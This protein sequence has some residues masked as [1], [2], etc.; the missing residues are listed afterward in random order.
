MEASINFLSYSGSLLQVLLKLITGCCYPGI[1]QYP[2][3]L[4]PIVLKKT[5]VGFCMYLSGFLLS[6]FDSLTKVLKIVSRILFC[7]FRSESKTS[8]EFSYSNLLSYLKIEFLLVHSF[9]ALMVT[10]LL[11]M[12]CCAHQEFVLAQSDV[13]VCRIELFA[14][15]STKFLTLLTEKGEDLLCA[16]NP[17]FVLVFDNYKE[18][19]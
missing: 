19:L 14:R 16:L 1:S 4:D 9:N 18:T 15:F 6:R 13:S 5:L 12:S 7:S 3:F 11:P 2:K 17:K 8:I 10:E